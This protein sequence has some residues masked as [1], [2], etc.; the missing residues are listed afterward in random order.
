MSYFTAV[1]TAPGLNRLPTNPCK[2][3]DFQ[4]LSLLD[5]ESYQAATGDREILAVILGG[6]ADFTVNGVQFAN[7]GAR[8]NVFAG[9]PYCVYIPCGSEYTVRAR[10]K[11][12]VGMPS[13]PSDLETAPYVIPP[14]KCTSGVWG[15]ANFSRNYQ[16]ILT[17]AGQP[18]LPARRLVVGET[19]TP[20]GNWS[21]YPPHK[22][23][24]DNLPYEAYQEEMY[25]FKLNPADG[26]GMIRYYNDDFDQ[27]YVVKD[28]TILMAP[29]G[30]HTTNSA[31]GYTS[32]FM[33][34]MAGN[35]RVQ[36]TH[37]DP[38]LSWVGRTVPMLKA[39]GH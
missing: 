30:Y 23:E 3:L 39:L 37:D 8:P 2:L 25:F 7:L 28:N 35:Q 17:V 36:A 6:K 24:V 34:F 38:V 33:W 27:A 18:D 13:A 4:Y 9:K 10:G 22:H 5:G 14:E 29:D 21:T 31:P 12:E 20:S 11:V 32:Y 19:Y 16:Q 26:F 15:A 1:P